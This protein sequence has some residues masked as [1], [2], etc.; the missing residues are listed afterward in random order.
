MIRDTHA[1]TLI[2]YVVPA[3][4]IVRFKGHGAEVPAKANVQGKAGVHFPVVLNIWSE[5]LEIEL[6]WIAHRAR[7]AERSRLKE[8]SILVVAQQHIRYGISSEIAVK[9]E[10]AQ[11]VVRKIPVELP[12][13]VIR[14]HR[15]GV[16]PMNIIQGVAHIP[17]RLVASL[18]R[19]ARSAY[20]GVALHANTRPRSLIVGHVLEHTSQADGI[21]SGLRSGNAGL[22]GR[23]F[24]EPKTELIHHIR[25]NGHRMGDLPV[26]GL[27]QEGHV[28]TLREIA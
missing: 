23:G 13:A 28:T 6:A 26:D 21:H 5:I 3:H 10:V 27:L 1:A 7:Q 17:H 20:A 14:A 22:I 19:V 2:S 24:Q 18:V 15:E 8:G 4:A 9:A 12:A 16:V 11:E 25:P